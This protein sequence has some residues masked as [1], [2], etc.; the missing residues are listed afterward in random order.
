MSSEDRDQLNIQ[1]EINKVIQARNAL[2]SKQSASL[3]SQAL[4][5]RE[6]C[7]ALKC[8]DLE[9]MEDRL[10]SIRDGLSG[11]ASK[12]EDMAGG[13]QNTSK[14]AS[15]AS[16]GAKTL[17]SGLVT[18][19]AAMGALV[20][21]A[22]GFVDGVKGGI[23]QLMM[24]PKVAG[25]IVKSFANIASGV[26]GMVGKISSTLFKAAYEQAV[27]GRKVAEAWQ[28]AVEKVGDTSV[29]AGA[30]VETAL[31]TVGDIGSVFGS[32][33]E[34]Q[35]AAVRH[36]AEL[37]DGLGALAT[38]PLSNEIGEAG[39][40]MLRLQ[41]GAGLS[42][43]ALSGIASRAMEAGSSVKQ[44]MS[45][46]VKAIATSAKK[47]G[48]STKSVGK[49][50][51]ALAK[52]P[53]FL[54]AT[55]KEMASLAETMIKTGTSAKSLLGIVKNFDTFEDSAENVSKL[56][57]AFGMNIDAVDMMNASDSER[58]AILQKSFKSTGK[59]I[60]DL[61][62]LERSY[63][64]DAAG[65]ASDELNSFF[66]DRAVAAGESGEAVQ[67]A[68]M[69]EVD[70]IKELTSSMK[71]MFK[72][73]TQFTSFFDAFFKGIERGFKDSGV[74]TG[75]QTLGESV[76]KLGEEAGGPM[77][78]AL[79]TMIKSLGGIEGILNTVRPSFTMLKE[80]IVDLVSGEGSIQERFGRAFQ[81]VSEF[82]IPMIMNTF[83][84][85]VAGVPKM[86]SAFQE[87]VNKP[88]VKASI[89]SA[90][91]TVAE[92]IKSALQNPNVQ[93]T[94]GAGLI[95]VLGKGLVT[96]AISA[97]P[98]LLLSLGSAL[99]TA[100]MGSSFIASIGG[101]LMSGLTTAFALLSNPAGWIAMIVLLVAGIGMAFS[102]F[103]LATKFN[104]MIQKYIVVPL[105][106]TF[107][108]GIVSSL[109][110]TFAGV[111]KILEGFGD[112]FFS[113]FGS[114]LSQTAN[115]GQKVMTGLVEAI[116]GFVM[117]IFEV[118]KVNL[119][120]LP[121]MILNGIAELVVVVIR[122]GLPLIG[123]IIS[124]I[125]GAFWKLG[126]MIGDA[127]YAAGAYVLEGLAS[128]G[129]SVWKFFTDPR[130]RKEAINKIK[131][132]FKSVFQA[133]AK[134][135][136]TLG[137]FLFDKIKR[138]FDVTGK[139]KKQ[140][141]KD[142]KALKRQE[143]DLAIAAA[144]AGKRE[145]AKLNAQKKGKDAVVT[146]NKEAKDLNKTLKNTPNISASVGMSDFRGGTAEGVGKVA[147]P[148]PIELS[149][150]VYLDANRLSQALADRTITTTPLVMG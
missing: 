5:A 84:A 25:G 86:L 51:D 4:I 101:G 35:A 149:V 102:K 22:K 72:P 16:K 65:V 110:D 1:T 97:I 90:I 96:A 17:S 130:Y 19:A 60:Q 45:T 113:I 54:H 94:V 8:K 117:T 134:S 140:Q 53:E 9:G 143:K 68:Q 123:N 119:T 75:V 89:N 109:A 40:L 115:A 127:L 20:A 112:F 95:Y 135:M 133:I 26:L 136:G 78:D 132:A 59:S 77:G 33:A 111:F 100:F 93:K 41:K 12:A 128:I 64:A 138:A 69:S 150:K 15:T 144:K 63:L 85:I 49:A 104:G 148:R 24:I 99:S 83:E 125:V 80:V 120:K 71:K 121:M 11:A 52:A 103:D 42:A 88:E 66:G 67:E 98:G 28:D 118:V 76:K 92:T 3:Q 145:E 124:F 139:Y 126:G 146:M 47:M 21:G 48:L 87:A 142:A 10:G 141:A 70:A 108:G 43:E 13:M 39:N 29:G 14:F 131:G 27:E 107:L 58:M 2:L 91:K 147:G 116:S 74:L 23:A 7:N 18:A 44:Q 56:T 61:S 122:Y 114:D 50:F 57:Q 32:Y 129:S 34:G 81:K 106:D 46:A 137:T 82:V 30:Q 62:R 55:V 79:G 6:L 36:M 31:G 38:G 105:K 37:V 73:L